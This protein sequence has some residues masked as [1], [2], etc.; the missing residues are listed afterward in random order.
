MFYRVHQVLV[1]TVTVSTFVLHTAESKE[2]WTADDSHAQFRHKNRWIL[3][4]R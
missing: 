1:V 2:K 4:S 3:R